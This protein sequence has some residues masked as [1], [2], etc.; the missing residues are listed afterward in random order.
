MR[1]PLHAALNH[2]LLALGVLGVFGV[3]G[4]VGLTTACHEREL[5]PADVALGG[6]L[7]TPG[8]IGRD[9]PP[10]MS[11]GFPGINFFNS[12]PCPIL[13]GD[14][15]FDGA[16][17]PDVPRGGYV[18]GNLFDR[19]SCEVIDVRVD[20]PT[21]PDGGDASFVIEGDAGRAEWIGR[22]V[23]AV[24]AFEALTPLDSV[25]PGSAL[26][27]I[28]TPTL[29]LTEASSSAPSL[30]INGDQTAPASID[31]DGVI[32]VT[33]PS[34]TP[35]GTHEFGLTASAVIDTGACGFASCLVEN[36]HG[37]PITITVVEF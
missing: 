23:F 22:D 20:A 36:V 7:R 18:E 25:T 11:L 24:R 10:S 28:L 33:V 2:L 19:E 30:D 12:D 27:F 1:L 26:R 8:V 34:A 35:A 5:V 32:T 6:T 31:D 14:V 29:V 3:V 15:S 21:K 16:V 9:L 4:V 13:T 17:L 37:E